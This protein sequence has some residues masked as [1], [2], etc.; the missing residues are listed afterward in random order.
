MFDVLEKIHDCIIKSSEAHQDIHDRRK[1]F[2]TVGN[3]VDVCMLEYLEEAGVN[4]NQK[5]VE[6][7]RN[8]KKVTKIP[9]DPV[10]K[11]M[12]VVYQQKND[13]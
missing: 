1:Q 12:T 6:R 2:F 11:R 3:P 7:G 10:T 4:V 9:F 13:N 8:F 5:L